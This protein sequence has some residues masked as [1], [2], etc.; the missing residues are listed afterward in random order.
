MRKYLLILILFSFSCSKDIYDYSVNLASF[1]RP[2]DNFPVGI[3]VYLPNESLAR[4]YYGFNPNLS[5]PDSID[6]FFLNW[7]LAKHGKQLHFSDS[8]QF[9]LPG[10]GSKDNIYNYGNFEIELNDTSNWLI[11]G[12]IQPDPGTSRYWFSK[13]FSNTSPFGREHFY[14][15]DSTGNVLLNNYTDNKPLV[16]HTDDISLARIFVY[17]YF[18]EFPVALPPFVYKKSNP[19]NYK[20]DSVFIMSLHNGESTRFK[21]PKQGFYHFLKDTSQREG[22]TIYRFPEGFPKLKE[23]GQLFESLRY[24]ASSQEYAKLSELSDKKIA[25]DRFWL[26]ISADAVLAV[27]KL[28]LYYRGVE[29]A[30][31]L[32]TSYHE[33]WKTDRGMV[34]IVFGPPDKV[35]RTKEFETWI[36]GEFKSPA[37]TGFDFVKVINPF[38]NNDYRIVKSPKYKEQWYYAVENWRR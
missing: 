1:Y 9:I 34:F 8:N 13:T 32:F 26:G 27:E 28:K 31:R 2:I 7:R 5:G 38:T 6:N 17:A 11:S 14:F 3:W 19:F 20:P 22:V 36:Y 30:N 33:G 25:T 23:P 15:T 29:E 10:K 35:F 12:T 4:V 18:R 24:I 16:L 21:L 37:M